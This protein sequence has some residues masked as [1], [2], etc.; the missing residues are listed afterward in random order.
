M[1]LDNFLERAARLEARGPLALLSSDFN[2]LKREVEQGAAAYKRQLERE[3]AAGETPH[4]CP[5]EGGVAVSSDELLRHFRSI[6]ASRRARLNVRE[7]FGDMMR[8]RYPCR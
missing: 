6:P 2:R 5:P 8:R 7:A 1:R 3:R 4:S